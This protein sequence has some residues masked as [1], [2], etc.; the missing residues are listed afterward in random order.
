MALGSGVMS[1][2]KLWKIAVGLNFCKTK[3][4][5]SAFGEFL[6]SG[7]Y[8][9]K[10]KIKYLNKTEIQ[11]LSRPPP[12]KRTQKKKKES[13]MRSTLRRMVLEQ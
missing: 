4:N 13:S 8:V 1:Q 5:P 3:C 10:L 11:R 2:Y 7:V 6:K 12:L 9:L